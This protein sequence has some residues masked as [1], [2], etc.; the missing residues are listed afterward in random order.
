MSTPDSILSHAYS[1][2]GYYLPKMILTSSDGCKVPFPGPDTIQ[3]YGVDAKFGNSR[4]VL[5][6]SGVVNFTD[7]SHAN[8]LVTGFHWDFG[9]GGSSGMQHPSHFYTSDGQYPVTLA[10]TTLRGCT[11]TARTPVPIKIVRSPLIGIAG[12]TGKC[13][14]AVLQLNSRVLVSDTP[15]VQWKWDLGNGN[16]STLQN[17]SATYAAAGSYS[18]WLTG[19]NTVGC[20]GTVNKT[21]EIYPVP[22]IDLG[23]DI[24][25]SVGSSVTLK[26]ALS[27]DVTSIAWQPAAG[28]SCT[29]CTTPVASPRQTITYTAFVANQRSCVNADKITIFVFCNNANLFLPNLFSPNNNGS[30]DYF[31]PRGRGLYTIKTLRIFN[32]WGQV[33]FERLGFKP[34]QERM[35][36]DG[37]HKGRPAPPDVYVYTIGVVCENGAEMTYSGNVLLLR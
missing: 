15:V 9:D 7:S 1:R 37:R 2:I 6:D 17:P 5:C 32:R 11:D 19:T 18:V 34:N 20:T 33:V 36:W 35:G 14:P 12:D 21:V 24:Q 25:L 31:Y 4:R 10:V 29:G 3:V 16:G 30:N 13:A 28:L 8:D 22:A 23:P 26:P 27:S